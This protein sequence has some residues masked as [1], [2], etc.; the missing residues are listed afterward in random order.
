MNKSDDRGQAATD[1]RDESAHRSRS[2]VYRAFIGSIC[3]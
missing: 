3:F 2:V 1:D